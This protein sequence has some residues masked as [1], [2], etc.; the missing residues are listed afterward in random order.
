MTPEA[1][2]KMS[3]TTATRNKQYKNTAINS[4]QVHSLTE[5]SPAIGPNFVN[6]HY[7]GEAEAQLQSY[8][9]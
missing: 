7:G 4:N 3:Q 5:A 6:S 1:S 8:I 2:R 9:L